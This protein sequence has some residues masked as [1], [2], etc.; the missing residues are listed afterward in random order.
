VISKADKKGLYKTHSF[1]VIP[2][3]KPI[4]I[5]KKGFKRHAGITKERPYLLIQ[6]L[7]LYKVVRFYSKLEFPYLVIT[8]MEDLGLEPTL[9]HTLT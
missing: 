4:N 5:L 6:P 2:A 3:R 8:W 1:E 9:P 7:L